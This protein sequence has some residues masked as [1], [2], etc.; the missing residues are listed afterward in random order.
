MNAIANHLK[1]LSVLNAA[2]WFVLGLLWLSY[3][4]V[5]WDLAA[6]HVI[7][8][9]GFV[10]VAFAIASSWF[11]AEWVLRS[12]GY[13]PKALLMVFA[14]SLAITLIVIWPSFLRLAII[15]LL[16]TFLAWQEIRFWRLSKAYTFWLIISVALS[17]LAI[18]EFL[19]L[20]V[21]PSN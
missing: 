3:A 5:G 11:G 17:A 10:I 6:D 14:L 15:P 18:G 21:L 4:L 16:T 20:W 1:V 13:I 9:G 19:D 8:F 12:L 7:W 2:S